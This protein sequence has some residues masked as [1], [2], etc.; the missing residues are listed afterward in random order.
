MIVKHIVTPS[1][2]WLN[3]QQQQQEAALFL[4]TLSTEWDVEMNMDGDC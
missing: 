4:V 1:R 3:Q 2:D